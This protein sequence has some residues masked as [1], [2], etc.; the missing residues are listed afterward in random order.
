MRAAAWYDRQRSYLGDEVLDE[1]TRAFKSLRQFPRAAPE[2][3]PSYRR[4]LLARFPFGLIYRFDGED[5]VIVAVAHNKR[6]SGYWRK[7]DDDA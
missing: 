7:R 6:R 2:I 3:F 4:L 5:I 1:I